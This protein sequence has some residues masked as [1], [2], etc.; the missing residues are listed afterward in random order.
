MTPIDV[1]VKEF[2]LP[3]LKRNMTLAIS[4]YF[5]VA[6]GA[7]IYGVSDKQLDA[8]ILAIGAFIIVLIGL[9]SL[10]FGWEMNKIHLIISP[11]GIEHRRPY[12]NLYASWDDIQY[13]GDFT[14]SSKNRSYTDT[15]LYIKGKTD[16]KSIWMKFIPLSHFAPNGDWKN[17]EIG[18]L[19]K[20]Y[21]PH[22]FSDKSRK[23]AE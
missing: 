6:I 17:H 15:G 5:V 16:Q 23:I 21:A 3:N 19:V 2:K 12:I 4:L 13:I 1:E 14:Y 9:T 10:W 8:L 7:Y 20:Q 11:D 22:L 18:A